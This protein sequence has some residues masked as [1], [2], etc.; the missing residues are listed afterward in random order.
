MKYL[1]NNGTIA[2]GSGG[3]P[4]KA[5]LLIENG[6]I[7]AVG[8]IYNP[9]AGSSE[10]TV[11][12]AS[13]KTVTPGFIDVH[14]HADLAV[15]KPGFGEA[16]LRQGL[17]TV[18]NGNCGLSVIP[19]PEPYRRD[20]LDFLAPVAGTLPEGLSFTDFGNYMAAVPDRLPLNVG[21]LIGSGTVRTAAAGYRSVLSG[22][23]I[24][25]IHAYLECALSDGAFGVSVG[26]QYVPDMYYDAAELIE[27][28]APLKGAGV[29]LCTHTRGDG[30]EL[31]EALGEVISIAE[32]VGTPLQVSHF[33]NMGRRYWRS[34]LPQALGLLDE[35]RNRGLSVN[36]DVYPYTF[37]T[38]QLIHIMP[39]SYLEGG[40][41]CLVERLRDRDSRKRLKDILETGADTSGP[42]E[43]MYRL[44]GWDSFR[45]TSFVTEANSIYTGKSIPEIAALR[46]T[47][48]FNCVC[49]LLIEEGGRI[50]ML[51]YITC[52]EDIADIMN[53]EHAFIISDAIYPSTGLPHPRVYGTCA[54]VIETYV[55]KLHALSLPAAV[56]K[57]TSQ[58]AEVFG[59][60]GKGLLKAGYD[61]DICIFDPA[62][63][64]ENATVSIPA[65]CSSGFDYVFVNGEPAVINDRLTGLKEGRRLYHR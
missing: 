60:T 33:K 64:H 35:A 25:S 44:L 29:P 28:L 59:I 51:D 1:I 14:R 63:I 22:E 56:R 53:Y 20:I 8:N 16:E 17:T 50:T 61:A 34:R 45:L 62:N 38:T 6:R 57:M 24:K 10:F 26:L 48:C 55:N 21:M 27:A 13:G 36:T 40:M 52:D 15:F 32:A 31:F 2:D 58:P 23:H 42:F 49:D 19:C 37:G 41:G 4:F 54:R 39:P 11:I 43:N 9:P 46:G 65:A 18:I 47:D 30:D 3:P 12:D 5:D 7:T